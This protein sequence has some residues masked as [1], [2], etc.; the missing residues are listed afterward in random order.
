MTTI[1]R[2]RKST[3]SDAGKDCV[4]V[5]HTRSALRDSKNGVILLAN[6]AAFGAFM[7]GVKTGRITR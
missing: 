7:D 3:R 6:P 4:E 2:W 5:A 1:L